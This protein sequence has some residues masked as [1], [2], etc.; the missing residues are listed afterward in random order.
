MGFWKRRLERSKLFN[1]RS[2]SLRRIT[3]SWSTSSN[4]ITQRQR[5]RRMRQKPPQWPRK[6]LIKRSEAM[7][8]KFRMS[9]VRS[10]RLLIMLTQSKPIKSSSTRYSRERTQ[11]G[12]RSKP[13]SKRERRPRSRRSGRKGRRIRRT[14]IT[15]FRSCLRW[16]SWTLKVRALQVLKDKLEMQVEALRQ[17]IIKSNRQKMMTLIRSLSY[18]LRWIWLM[19]AKTTTMNRSFLITLPS[20]WKFTRN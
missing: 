8:Q 3:V 13:A 4:K 17:R 6:S 7:I 20:S 10:R 1:I 19:S 14:H 15:I 11:S 2:L 16:L 18:C 9:G 5:R 12:L